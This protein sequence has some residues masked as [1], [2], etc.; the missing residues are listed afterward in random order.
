M[1]LLFFLLK[2]VYLTKLIKNITSRKTFNAIA[3]LS[4]EVDSQ[5]DEWV[6]ANVKLQLGMVGREIHFSARMLLAAYIK[7][8]YSFHMRCGSGESW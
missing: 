3:S 5:S 6:K 4:I 2:Q 1:V 8:Y 7:M